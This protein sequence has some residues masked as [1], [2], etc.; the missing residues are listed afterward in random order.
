MLCGLR[1]TSGFLRKRIEPADREAQSNSDCGAATK[2]DPP[3]KKRRV[4]FLIAQK[5]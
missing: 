3:E 5:I 4:L 1:P 2:E